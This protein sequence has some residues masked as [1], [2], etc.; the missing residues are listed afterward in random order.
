MVGSE[1]VK[2]LRENVRDERGRKAEP[3]PNC[4]RRRYILHILHAILMFA[5]EIC[6]II[7]GDKHK[8]QTREMKF[9]RARAGVRRTN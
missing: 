8:I 3:F 5:A 9:L 7:K 1:C 6:V 4:V 2:Y